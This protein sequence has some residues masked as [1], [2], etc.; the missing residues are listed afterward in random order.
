[1]HKD[2]IARKV[3]EFFDCTGLCRSPSNVIYLLD[4][5]GLLSRND[6]QNI[7]A[8]GGTTPASFDMLPDD[9]QVILTELS[10]PDTLAFMSIDVYKLDVFNKWV[11]G[12]V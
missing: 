3:G 7:D 4:L 12:A 5:M 11:A 9:I 1:M 6:E 8:E 2:E 10:I